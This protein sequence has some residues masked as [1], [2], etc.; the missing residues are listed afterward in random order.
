MLKQSKI[1]TYTMK[2]NIL[3]LSVIAFITFS[4]K[5]NDT[6]KI[7]KTTVTETHN[8]LAIKTE[9]WINERVENAK[10]KLQKTQAG[11]IIWKAMEAHGGLKN[12]YSNGPIAFNFDYKPLDKK[13]TRRNTNQVID[14]WSN[15]ARHQDVNNHTNEFGWTGKIAWVKTKDTLAFPFDKRFWALTPY[16]FLAQPFVLDGQGVNLE[17]LE[18][19]VYKNNNHYAIKVTFNA[20][21][22][23]APDDYYVLYF[24]KKDYKLAVIR[25]IVSYPEYFKKGGHSPEKFMEIQGYKTINN[26]ILPTEYH[27]HW[28]TKKETAGE[29]ITTITVNNVSFKPNTKNTYF[30]VPENAVIIK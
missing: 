27:T 18:D 6:V 3:L 12:W 30:N 26:I 20:G 9:S 29:H 5:K 21:T 10:N 14:T 19:K 7:K 24:N 13:K 23:D 8:N 4:C 1:T 25:Y 15:K 16:Y 2:R 22:G 11:N 17:K 28:L